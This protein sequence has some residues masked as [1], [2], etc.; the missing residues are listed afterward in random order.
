VSPVTVSARRAHVRT[1]LPGPRSAPLLARQAATES[2]AR[3]YPRNSPIA[4]ASGLGAYVTDADGNCFLDFL[5]GS[6]ALPLGHQHPALTDAARDQLGV[7]ATSLLDFPTPAKEEFVTRLL[8][9]LP[10]PM[11]ER[12]KLHFCGPAGADAVDA[13]VKLC[14]TAT[15]RAEVVCFHGGFHGSTQ[16]TLALS[17]LRASM[18]KIGNLM[19]GAAFF[20][21]PYC[22]RCPLGLRPG[23][24]QINCVQYLENLLADPNGGLRAPAAIVLELVQGEGGV[25]PARP[26]FV[27]RLRELAT[28]HDIPLVVDEV[29]TGCGR[30]GTWY[31]FEQ[32]GIEP[33][34]VVSS[35]A[36]GG[37][38]PTAV[39]IYDRRLD[40]WAPGAHTG[41]FRGNQLAFAAGAALMREVT[42]HDLLANVRAVGGRLRAGLEDLAGRYPFLADVRGLGLMLGTEITAAGTWPATQVAR[43]LQLAALRGGLLFELAGRGSTVARFL[44]PLN[45][46][47]GQADEA[48]DILAAAVAQVDRRSRQAGTGDA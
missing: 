32:Y 3:T 16:S 12:S 18:G 1:E 46:E 15:G 14:K 31:A 11:R 27:T 33:D 25:I 13:A 44:P 47:P 36:L 45:L 24:C 10:A 40:V 19:P 35:K 42:E 26:E 22:F 5:S 29:Q 37:G 21:Y 48:L 9:L 41:T 17:G 38:H 23:D 20:P 39:I 2:S 43:E 7:A 6:G 4:I 8:G 34:V 28:R 30:T